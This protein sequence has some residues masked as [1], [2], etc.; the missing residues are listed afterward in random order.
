MPAPTFIRIRVSPAKAA[1][2]SDRAIAGKQ[3][4]VLLP[5]QERS[6]SHRPARSKYTFLTTDVS[7][8]RPP[9]R[10]LTADA[11]RSRARATSAS[12]QPRTF[13]PPRFDVP[14]PESGRGWFYY[15]CTPWP[16][17]RHRCAHLVNDESDRCGAMP[18]RRGR[19]LLERHLGSF[20]AGANGAARPPA[21]SAYRAPASRSRGAARRAGDR[22]R[23]PCRR[24]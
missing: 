20:A 10:F 8:P 5:C 23:P 17:T 22:I 3:T 14:L 19:D 2:S 18:L 16:N 12:G 13:G 9:P 24:A 1:I 7:V 4:G 11:H 15:E 6:A 21:A